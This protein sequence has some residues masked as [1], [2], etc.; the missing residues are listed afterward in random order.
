MIR[1]TL[2]T[3]AGKLG[4]AKYDEQA[5]RVV[6]NTL[7]E[8]GYEEDRGASAVMECAGT[9]KLQHDTGKNLKTVVIFPKISTTAGVENAMGK[10]GLNENSGVSLIAEGSIE[11]KLVQ[12]TINVFP[13][14]MESKCETWTQ[15]KGCIAALTSLK[16]SAER[17][18][19]KLLQGNPLTDAEQEFYN[20]VSLTSLEEKLT[21]V[22]DLM[23]KQVDSG[24]ITSDEKK[25]LLE[26]ISDRLAALSD[27]VSEAEAQSKVKRVEN[28]KMQIEKAK[29][30]QAKIQSL[31]TITLPKLKNLDAII[32][33]RKELLPLLEVEQAAKG[34]LL[35]LK[36]S[37]AVARK[38][39]IS[40]EIHQL[41]LSSRNWFESD[42]LFQA[43]VK[44]SHL[45]WE[46]SR[47]QAAAK[48]KTAPKV[49]AT[50]G[51]SSAAT[52]W[53]VPGAKKTSA[54]GQ[55]SQKGVKTSG[56]LFAQM[57]NDSDSD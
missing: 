3:G 25:Q 53:V 18:D 43:R 49:T 42:D 22:R 51:S 12:T 21:C 34:R 2:V 9:F 46:K 54:W 28:L 4:R 15:K 19:L 38:D 32:K 48:K 45:D 7:R 41:E 6:T 33:L 30:R 39:E 24:H 52:K 31:S 10:V 56:G 1:L 27:E 57:M 44:A 55:P 47:K 35:T 26:Q 11:E 8:L 20:T 13:R 29:L 17:L 16:T 23:A 36:E 14:M 5:A 40:E 50:T 37:Q